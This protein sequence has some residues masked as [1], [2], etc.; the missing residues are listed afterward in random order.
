MTRRNLFALFV[1]G[2]CLTHVPG[3]RAQTAFEQ[4]C[5]RLASAS[6]DDT[7]RLHQLFK[8]DWDHTMR[9]NPEFATEVGYP[10]QNDRWTDQSLEAIEQRKRELHAPMKVIQSIDRSK[11]SG[12][13]QLNYDLFKKNHEDAIEGSRFKSEYMPLTQLNGIHHDVAEVLEI[14]PHATVKDFEDMIAR[15]N[16][17]PVLISQIVVLMNKGIETGITPTRITLRD[18]PQQ[19]KNQMIED[20]TK[21]AILKPFMEFPAEIPGKEGEHLRKEA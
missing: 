14:S 2:F 3:L 11:L 10:G 5:A 18:V 6:A 17:V 9:E 12:A 19:I 13:D 7:E 1:T 20:P 8:L 15:L 16:A 4:D 21:N